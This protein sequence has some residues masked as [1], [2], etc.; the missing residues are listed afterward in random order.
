MS[1]RIR[2]SVVNVEKTILQ[3]VKTYSH[4]EN[5]ARYQVILNTEKQQWQVVDRVTDSIISSGLKAHPVK[6]RLEARNALE[7]LGIPMNS[8]T[9]KART[10]KQKVVTA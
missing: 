9:R 2:Y 5:G 7:A 6:L 10:P 8:E 4:P 3:S 1:E